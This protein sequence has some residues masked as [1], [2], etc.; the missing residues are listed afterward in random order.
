VGFVSTRFSPDDL[1][2][3]RQLADDIPYVIFSHDQSGRVLW[4]NRYFHDITQITGGDIDNPIALLHTIVKDDLARCFHTVRVALERGGMYEVY[5]RIKPLYASESAARWHFVRALPQLR[6]V[7]DKSNWIVTATDV[8]D[9]YHGDAQLHSRPHVAQTEPPQRIVWRADERGALVYLSPSWFHYTA[10]QPSEYY[11]LPWS[12][13]AIADSD[14]ATVGS[15]WERATKTKAPFEYDCRLIGRNGVQ[16]W[17]QVRGR[18]MR[19]ADNAKIQW[20]GTCTDIDQ[21]KRS[22]LTQR[23]VLES[24]ARIGTVEQLLETCQMLSEVTSSAEDVLPVVDVDAGNVHQSTH[25]RGTTLDVHK[26]KG[27]FPG[28][29][30]DSAENASVAPGISPYYW[31]DSYRMIDGR[32]FI[33]IGTI[34]DADESANGLAMAMRLMLRSAS[35]MHSEPA[36]MLSIA[37]RALQLDE[38]EC[39]VSACVAI[40]DPLTMQFEYA[41]RAHAAMLYRE[42]DGRVIELESYG[43][44][45]GLRDVS[46]KINE[47]TR[48]LHLQPGSLLVLYT[49]SGVVGSSAALQTGAALRRL[50]HLP[51]V[52]QAERPAV[53][54][55]ESLPPGSIDVGAMIVLRTEPV[56]SQLSVP[57]SANEKIWRWK[58]DG[59]RCEESR[60][61]R[62]EITILLRPCG[63]SDAEIC[64]FEMIF[65]ELV[66]NVVRHASNE[67]E[68]LLDI[69][70]SVP[71]LHVIDQGPGFVFNVH[72]PMNPL[73]ESG[74]GLYIISQVARDFTVESSKNGGS[75][76]RVVLPFD[77]QSFTA[78]EVLR[79]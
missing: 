23:F 76:A 28:L 68:V 55:A 33:S 17:F 56:A 78:E 64:L 51:E 7:A 25:Y 39:L 72:L 57:E 36:I 19:D 60:I 46:A 26:Q 58:F 66:G 22:L 52:L 79:R 5:L 69:L 37:D 4:G 1:G 35:Q 41:S 10:I 38:R 44:P 21:R 71:V 27:G 30:M 14:I 20:Y 32:L 63:A 16:R 15:V 13:A 24:V 3:I 49:Q 29:I 70:T 40:L 53:A 62:D 34:L 18:A 12:A 73:S 59:S 8:H 45:L 11:G 74:R 43:P 6:D 77:I 61:V 9:H 54:L 31:Y 2:R 50:M 48:V 67:V 42:S 75:H 47:Q 65:S